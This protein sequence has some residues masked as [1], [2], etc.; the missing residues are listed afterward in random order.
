MLDVSSSDRIQSRSHAVVAP[1]AEDAAWL[2]AVAA[3][4]AV[5]ISLWTAATLTSL[6]SLALR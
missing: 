3:V 2:F 5:S 1:A 4:M 6:S